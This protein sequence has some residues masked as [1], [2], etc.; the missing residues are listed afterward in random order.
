MKRLVCSCLWLAIV[1][2]CAAQ[3][4]LPEFGEITT[5]EQSLTECSFDKE[6]DAMIIFD[7]ASADNN[8]QHNLI[9]NRRIRL[10]IL[11]PK[12]NQHGDIS[13]RYYHKDDLEYINGIEAYTCNYHNNLPDIKKV[14]PSAIYRQKI[15]D[16]L[17]VVRIPM[18]DVQPGS[19]IEY[20]YTTTKKYYSWLDD[21]Y[22]QSELPTLHSRFS[23]VVMPNYAFSYRV[24]K[25]ELLPIDIKHEKNSGRIYFGMDSIAGL[26]DEPYMDAEKDYLQHV[27]F[28][29]SGYQGTFGG[30]TKTR[31][32][33]EEVIRELMFHQ[34]FGLQLNKHIPV[35][36]EWE[37]TIKSISSP[38]EKMASIYNFVFKN[39]NWSGIGGF[40]S[41]N[42]VKD[43]WEKRKGN[44][45]DINLMLINLLME[46]GLE[47]YPLLVSTRGH[48]KVNSEIPFMDQFNRVM[49]YVVIGDKKYVLDATGPYTPPFMIPFSVI[50]TNALIVHRKKGG[51]ITLTETEKQDRNLVNIM[52]SIDEN[53]NMKG[54]ALIQSYDYARLNRLGAWERDKDRFKE[55]YYTSYQ[56][57][58]T[59]DSLIVKNTDNDS[60]PFGQRFN[61]FIPPTASGDYKLIN[62]NLFSGITKNPFISDIRF[63]NIDYGC[64]QSYTVVENITLPPSMKLETVPKN[65]RLIMPDTSIALSRYIQVKDNILNVKYAIT[66]SRSVFT[67]EDYEYVKNFY[68]KMA[69]IMNEQIV[70]KKEN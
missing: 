13:I 15:N 29:L 64:L 49:A 16:R 20:K 57:G 60:L 1:N 51:I 2:L 54:E 30:T 58:L 62:L 50:N 69:E 66:T 37:N 27:E 48:G 17:S 12:G 67:A 33:W 7:E 47:A 61:F 25:S 11:K 68:K 22:F 44:S 42:G 70:L 5:A 40:T 26:R 59:V 41:E 21:W 35:G 8:D 24:R 46:S 56:P 18:P 3:S 4:P 43:T 6:A 32:N 65:I 9:V 10:K 23:L 14:P 28:Q 34:V 52:A 36:S 63:T 19:I 45:G 53:G 31:T 39:F 55:E 38:Y